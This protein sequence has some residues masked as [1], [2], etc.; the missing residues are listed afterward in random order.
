[1]FSVAKEL[2]LS[3]TAFIKKQFLIIPILF[4]ISLQK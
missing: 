1:M 4:V 3:E 2:G